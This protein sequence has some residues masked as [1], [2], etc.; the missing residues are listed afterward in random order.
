MFCNDF[1]TSENNSNFQSLRYFILNLRANVIM[2]YSH[3]KEKFDNI[4]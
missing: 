1:M 2:S 4:K 3:S